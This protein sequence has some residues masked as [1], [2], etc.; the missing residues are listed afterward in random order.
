[1]LRGCGWLSW[2]VGV[3][4]GGV[5]V[6]GGGGAAHA[7]RVRAHAHTPTREPTYIWIRP[8]ATTQ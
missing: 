5:V 8:V 3:C 7:E 1:V 2:G 6:V 4:W